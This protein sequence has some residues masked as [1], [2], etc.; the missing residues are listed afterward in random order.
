MQPRQAYNVTILNR[1]YLSGRHIVN[2]EAIA[3]NVKAMDG[4]R[5]C[6]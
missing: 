6:R 3:A 1:S 4:I 2:A 5:D